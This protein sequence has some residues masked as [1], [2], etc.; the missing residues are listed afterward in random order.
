MLKAYDEDKDLYATIGTGVWNNDYWDNMEHYE[1]G[2]PNV[3]GKKRRSKC[4]K[5]LL[6]ITYGMGP[7]TTAQ[8]MKV[9][10]E[11]AKEIIEKFYKGFPKVKE[12]VENNE[13]FV[14]EHG[15]VEDIYGRRRRLPDAMLPEREFSIEGSRA[16][17]P[18]LNSNSNY[19][20]DEDKK[21]FA[22]YNERLDKCRSQKERNAINEEAA[23][24]GI[25]IRNNGGFIS[26]A[27]RQ[28]TNARIQGSAATMTKKAMILIHNDEL[29]H[30]LGFRLLI[31]VHDE[32]IGE[33]PIEN[34]EAAAERLS[35]L[36]SHSV[37]DVVYNVKF[38]CD[39][40]IEDHWYLNTYAHTVKAEYDK[41]VSKFG[42][43]EAF[44]RISKD[45][46]ESTEDLIK[47][48]ISGNIG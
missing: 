11:E 15:Y 4:K 30:K 6:G 5:L 8:N 16:V 22:S 40:E 12:L 7:A 35:Y 45:H 47:D 46:S 43:E 3:E 32:L 14:V 29:M 39:A 17:N 36:M 37:E 13:K 23:R 25:K 21:L 42:E 1:D 31:G 10:L 20:S 26:R 48:I 9:S 44:N 41:Y 2:S 27:K 24:K 33:C 34:A 19:I 18:L 38:K 28:C